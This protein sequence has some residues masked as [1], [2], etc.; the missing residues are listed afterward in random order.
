M[1][2]ALQKLNATTDAEDNK[3]A[4][5]ASSSGSKLSTKDRLKAM[6]EELKMIKHYL[7]NQD[8]FLQNLDAEAR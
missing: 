5:M 8:N 6:E 1:F 2:H 7:H 4:E 3:V